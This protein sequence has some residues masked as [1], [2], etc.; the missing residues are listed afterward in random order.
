[1]TDVRI[2]DHGSIF[3]FEL[4]TDEAREFVDDH[5]D[6]DANYFGEDRLVVE[7]RFAG[8]LAQGLSDHGLEVESEAKN[9]ASESIY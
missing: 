9:S 4:L 7:H 5:V 8:N 1:M 2:V 3:I 6:P